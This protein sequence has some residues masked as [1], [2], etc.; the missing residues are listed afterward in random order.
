MTFKAPFTIIL[1]LQKTESPLEYVIYPAL[2]IASLAVILFASELFTNAVEWA[3]KK[4]DLSHGATGSILA[5]VGTALPE[6]TIPVI[7]LLTGNHESAEVAVG[8]IAGA[9][10]MLSTLALCVS[11]V[12]VYYYAA[13]GKRSKE[14]K[15]D[16]AVKQ[17]DLGFFIVIYS[18]AVL[19]TFVHGH[20]FR[21]A[22]ALGLMFS[23]AIYMFITLRHEGEAEGD[24][25]HLH[26]SRLFRSHRVRRRFILLQIMISL[27]LIVGGA[28]YFVIAVQRVS[29]MVGIPTMLL[30]LLITPVATELPEK[31]NSVIWIRGG[32]D[33]LALGN[34]T[35]A[36]VF[37]ASFPVAIGVAFTN[38]ELTGPTMVS[39][40]I[41]LVA[42]LVCYVTLKVKKRMPPQLLLACG[43]LYVLFIIY[44]LTGF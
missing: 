30:S 7:A 38:W 39:A 22:V 16:I 32:K 21:H 44:L 19:T 6:T 36:M 25:E 23:Y 15:L 28:H 35:G 20:G 17:R 14:L 4:M 43:G 29:H 3:G 27:G 41:A 2:L 26:L 10:F 1:A 33:T 11:G 5:A 40:I 31:M 37:Q 24:L 42:S 18:V 8:A 13:R 9:P 34:I 12:A